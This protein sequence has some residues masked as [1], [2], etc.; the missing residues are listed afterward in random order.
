MSVVTLPALEEK[1][2]Y[3]V[4]QTISRVAMMV[5]SASISYRNQYAMS[6]PGFMPI[7]GDAFGQTRGSHYLSPGLDFAFGLVGDSYINKAQDN[8][9]LLNDESVATPATTNLTEDLQLK[10]TIEPIKNLK[11][12]LTASRTE[13]K[14]RSIQYMYEG[15]PTTQ[16]G[17]L[18]MT[19]ISLSSAFESM[20]N[21]NNGFYSKT[22][23]KFCNSLES[24]PPACRGTICRDHLSVGHLACRTDI[25]CRQWWSQQVL[26]RRHG[27]CLP[28]SLH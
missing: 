4:A 27:A 12:D 21:A 26:R 10:A 25:R 20:G 28:Q 23:E 24:L 5:R 19:T 14:A 9:W 16:T 3:K 15:N 17:S 1:K 11:I 13:T 22:F 18:S 7:I 8:N 6:I 2:W